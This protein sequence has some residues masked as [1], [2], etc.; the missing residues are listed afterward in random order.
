MPVTNILISG[1]GGQG[2]VLAGR[3]I[4]SVAFRSGYDVKE[5]EI[6]GMAQRGGT[7]VA[8]IRFGDIVYSPHIPIGKADIMVALEE[9]EAL[10]YLHYLKNFGLV[11]LNKKKILPSNARQED[12]PENVEVQIKLKGFSVKVIEA[13]KVAK[14]LG[15]PKVENSVILGVLSEYL[16]FKENIWQEVISQMVPQKTVDINIK[17]FNEGRRLAEQYELLE[18]ANRDITKGET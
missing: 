2:I 7:V 17:A 8:H 6:H 5:S 12:Y 15:N 3:I 4:A 11:I 16:P 1:T 9:L 13:E 18:Q 10:R 14:Q